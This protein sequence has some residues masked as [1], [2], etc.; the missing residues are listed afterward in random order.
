[1][2]NLTSHLTIRVD[3][4]YLN[5]FGAY[6]V[7]LEEVYDLFMLANKGTALAMKI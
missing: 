4:V 3:I 5:K 2:F 7:L 6:V 1:M